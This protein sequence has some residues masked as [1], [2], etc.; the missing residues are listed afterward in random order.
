MKIED[1]LKLSNEWCSIFFFT[2]GIFAQVFGVSL[3]IAVAHFGLAAKVCGYR[4]KKLGNHMVLRAGL[5]T[6][7]LEQRYGNMLIKHEFGYEIKYGLEPNDA[8]Y[9]EWHDENMANLLSQEQLLARHKTLHSESQSSKAEVKTACAPTPTPSAPQENLNAALSITLSKQE[10]EFLQSWLIDKYPSS[11][12]SG[13]I[14]G[15]QQ[16]VAMR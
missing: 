16:K 8:D 2:E 14:R 11:I 7:T 1:K 3:Y 15:L 6:K 5:P 9:Q 13:F 4:Y 10:V 12:E